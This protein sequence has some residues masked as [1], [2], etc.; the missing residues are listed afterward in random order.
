MYNL[1]QA[2]SKMI[3]YGFSALCFQP[4]NNECTIKDNAYKGKKEN[5]IYL[6]NKIFTRIE[7]NVHI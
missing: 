1:Y 7:Q 4:N 5:N 2:N 3:R 6:S